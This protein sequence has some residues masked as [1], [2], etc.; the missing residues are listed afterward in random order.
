MS[1]A[2]QALRDAGLAFSEIVA[3]G[4][5]HRARKPND[6]QWYIANRGKTSTG[7]EWLQL[8]AGD[9]RETGVSAVLNM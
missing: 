1:A 2:I 4:Y 3:D 7:K 8:S 9:F 5:F 6:A